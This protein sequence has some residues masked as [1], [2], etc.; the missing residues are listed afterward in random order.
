MRFK[1][2]SMLAVVALLGACE[3]SS[4]QSG[5]AGGAGGAGTGVGSTGNYAKGSPEEFVSNVGDRVFFDFDKYN[6]SAEGRATLDKQAAWLKA[7]QAAVVT[8]EGHCD[9]R[10]T[11]EYNLALG[12]RR[13][14]SAKDYL[15]S[16]GVAASRV[17]TISYGKERPVALGHDEGAWKQNR[18]AVT[19][20]G[21]GA[22]S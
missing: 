19:V 11:R 12:E 17:K 5:T 6:V 21:K 22:G 8:I 2:L 1:I 18:R 9:E 4:D 7:N 16:Q 20:I 14:H 15:V 10:G 13:A 3:T